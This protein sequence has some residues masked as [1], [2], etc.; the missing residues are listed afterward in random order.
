M[1]ANKTWRPAPRTQA[2]LNEPSKDSIGTG[3]IPICGSARSGKTT[4]ALVQP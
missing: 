2:L 4:L 1:K 3:I